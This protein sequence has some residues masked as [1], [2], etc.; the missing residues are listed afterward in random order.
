MDYYVRIDTVAVCLFFL[1]CLVIIMRGISEWKWSGGGGNSLGPLMRWQDTLSS[2]VYSKINASTCLWLGLFAHPGLLACA[3]VEGHVMLNNWILRASQIPVKFESFFGLLRKW[4]ICSFTLCCPRR[5]TWSWNSN[6]SWN[7]RTFSFPK[8]FVL[9]K[10][11]SSFLYQL[12][13]LRGHIQCR[14]IQVLTL[15]LRVGAKNVLCLTVRVHIVVAGSGGLVQTVG[16]RPFTGM[17]SSFW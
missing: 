9:F 5:D 7:F 4:H 15:I 1:F 6:F 2:T 11:E 3:C 10:V 8:M 12:K 14:Q 17:I 13:G 16:V